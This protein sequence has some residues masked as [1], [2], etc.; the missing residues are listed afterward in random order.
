MSTCKLLRPG[1][2]RNG[3]ELEQVVPT[4]Q[5]VVPEWFAEEGLVLKI[6]FTL[7]QRFIL[8]HFQYAASKNFS[9]PV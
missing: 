1:M 9:C 7:L 6:P 2:N 4:V 3:S 5:Q 8:V